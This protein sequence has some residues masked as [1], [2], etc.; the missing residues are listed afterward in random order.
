MEIV[1]L[2]LSFHIGECGARP[3]SSPEGISKRIAVGQQSTRSWPWQAEFI[4]RDVKGKPKHHC[5]G[6]L[7]NENYILTAAHCFNE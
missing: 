7:L 2:N 1:H 5:G 4:L 3:E 6:T